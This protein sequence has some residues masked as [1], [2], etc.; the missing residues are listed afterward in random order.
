MEKSSNK[1]ADGEG[2]AIYWYP[3]PCSF[4]AEGGYT[5]YSCRE[6]LHCLPGNVGLLAFCYGRRPYCS[7][8]VCSD[9]N[10]EKCYDT[11]IANT[12]NVDAH[13]NMV[14]QSAKLESSVNPD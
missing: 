12:T 5:C 9:V 11:H 10:E 8:G 6:S 1:T 13:E 14:E 7:N 2:R 4:R 3:T